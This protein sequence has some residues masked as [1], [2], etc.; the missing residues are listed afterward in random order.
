MFLSKHDLKL[1]YGVNL[2]IASA[3]VDRKVPIQ[4]LYWKSREIYVPSAPGYYFMPIFSD[5]LF[6]CGASKEYLLSDEYFYISE[7]ILHSA[8]LLEHELITWNKHVQEIFDFIIP[9]IKRHELFENLKKYFAD[10]ILKKDNNS[11]LGTD[12]P[13]LNRAD[14]YLLILA[15]IPTYEFNE[16]KAIKS[17]YALMTYFLILDDLADIKDDLIKIQENVLIDVG[18]N[19]IG[20]QT[21]YNMIDESYDFLSTVNPIMANRIDH[22]REIMDLQELLKSIIS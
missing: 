4:N 5:L 21:I 8:A 18:L 6:R 2:Q 17:W 10:P 14:S 13:S 7:K 12:F 20:I 16:Q 9:Y 3:F 22:K 15:C 1:A 11:F 19:D